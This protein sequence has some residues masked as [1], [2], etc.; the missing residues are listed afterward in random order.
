[1]LEQGVENAGYAIMYDPDVVEQCLDAGVGSSLTVRLGGK[2]DDQ[3]GEPIEELD[4]YVKAITD[5]RYVNTGTSHEGYG[6]QNDLGPTVHLQCGSDRTLDVIVSGVRESAFDAEV[7]RH[8]GVMPERLDVLCIPSF[9]AFLGDYKPLSSD[10]VLAD[11]PGASAVNPARF[12][13]DHIPRPIYPL[14]DVADIT[15]PDWT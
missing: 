14:D 1:M 3:H 6:V 4:V 9:I 8:I 15:Y 11:T 5:G 7:W 13:Y 12:E 2:T 10:V